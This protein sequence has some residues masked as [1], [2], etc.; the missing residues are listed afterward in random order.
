MEETHVNRVTFEA[1]NNLDFRLGTGPLRGSRA[2]AS[3]DLA[4]I[5]RTSEESYE[6]RIARQGTHLFDL[7]A[8]Y[9]INFI[10]HRGKRYGY[11]DNDDFMRVTGIRIPSVPDEGFN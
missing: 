7:L 3:G 10:G 1:E 5:S 8:P 2:A 9:A 4:V 6:L 11:I